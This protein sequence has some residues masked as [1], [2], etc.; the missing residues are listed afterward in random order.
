MDSYPFS[1]IKGLNWE[2]KA[3]P[4]NLAQFELITKSVQ[5]IAF[6]VMF[7]QSNPIT[8][9]DQKTVKKDVLRW[10]KRGP[11]HSPYMK[12]WGYETSWVD[13]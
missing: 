10:Q 7:W 4:I 8:S 6:W 2:W 3:S 11:E 13:R 5:L 1:I 9:Y 12:G